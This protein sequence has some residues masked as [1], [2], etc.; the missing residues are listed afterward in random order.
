MKSKWLII[1]ILVVI[2][3]VVA[4]SAFMF[5][6]TG[7]NTPKIKNYTSNGISFSYNGSW[8]ASSSQNGTNN[9]LLVTDTAAIN[10]SKET[11][12][13]TIQVT[14]LNGFTETEAVNMFSNGL[15]PDN[16]KKVSTSNLTVDNTTAYQRIFLSAN[17][18]NFGQD[19]RY[20]QIFFVK[21]GNQYYITLQAPD[22]TFDSEK[23]NFD[24]IVNS[25]KVQ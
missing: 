9:L 25:F 1:P 20:A 18:P 6:N 12:T 11:T 13:I 4:V 23:S 3:A 16:W 10:Q 21:N 2:I 17:D 19:M 15:V 5:I 22:K 7:D 14:P 8:N 24:M